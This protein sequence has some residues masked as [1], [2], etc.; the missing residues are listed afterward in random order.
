[1][2]ATVCLAKRQLAPALALCGTTG[3]KGPCFRDEL[4]GSVMQTGGAVYFYFYFILE[5]FLV[6]WFGV[7]VRIVYVCL[8]IFGLSCRYWSDVRE[9]NGEINEL[10]AYTRSRPSHRLTHTLG[11]TFSGHF[12]PFRPVS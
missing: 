10:Y 12:P 4:K 9:L 8:Y 6:V 7:V 3:F 11:R 5:L 1:M 2:G